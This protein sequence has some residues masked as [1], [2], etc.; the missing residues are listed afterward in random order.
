M[1]TK[2]RH[3]DL[4]TAIVNRPIVGKLGMGHRILIPRVD[5][6][7]LMRNNALGAIMLPYNIT[8]IHCFTSTCVWSRAHCGKQDGCEENGMG[9]CCTKDSNQI[10]KVIS[11]TTCQ[12]FDRL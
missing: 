4:V 3:F 11:K 1:P 12:T 8:T 10:R 2:Y 6:P 9:G 7:C 5:M